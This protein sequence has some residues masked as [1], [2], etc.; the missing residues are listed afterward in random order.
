MSDISF[1]SCGIIIVLRGDFVNLS[2]FILIGLPLVAMFAMLISSNTGKYSRE[3]LA[4]VFSARCN[5]GE[6]PDD[7]PTCC[8]LVNS[9]TEAELVIDPIWVQSKL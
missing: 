7:V 9:L 6:G 5:D 4:M 8:K 1:C 2:A 3:Y